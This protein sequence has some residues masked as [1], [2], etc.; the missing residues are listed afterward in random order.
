MPSDL[1]RA[2]AVLR[3]GV[4]CADVDGTLRGIRWDAAGVTPPT[5]AEVDATLAELANPP[6][7]SDAEKLERA[8]G[9]SVAKIKTVLAGGK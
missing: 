7:Q 6:S 9:L 3:P 5:Q 4:D 1:M 8:T 2:V